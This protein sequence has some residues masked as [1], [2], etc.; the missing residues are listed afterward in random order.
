MENNVCPRNCMYHVILGCG[1]LSAV[2][3]LVLHSHIFH[4]SQWSSQCN[5]SSLPPL[6]M[7]HRKLALSWFSVVVAG[8]DVKH[9]PP[10]VIHP[11]SAWKRAFAPF[12]LTSSLIANF[13]CRNLHKGVVR[14][15]QMAWNIFHFFDFPWEKPTRLHLWHLSL[16]EQPN[17]DLEA[18]NCPDFQMSIHGHPGTPVSAW[19]PAY[20]NVWST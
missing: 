18:P 4:L 19:S 8:S 20:G 16:F 7:L 17:W 1:S 2:D 13:W 6:W 5:N 3:L 9:I 15:C 14:A 11:R 10:S 12:S